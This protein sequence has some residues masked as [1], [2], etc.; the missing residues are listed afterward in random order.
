MSA[1]LAHQALRRKIE[2]HLRPGPSAPDLTAAAGRVFGRALRR[3]AGPFDGLGLLLGPVTVEA[4][5]PLEAAIAALP[6]QGLVA[7]LEDGGGQRGLMGLSP[8]LVDALV[9]VQTTGRVEAAELA[10][11][12]VTRIDEALARDF[13]DLALAGFA[14]EGQGI[15]GRDWPERMGYG[16][17]IR[18]RGQINLLL[19]EGGYMILGA[20]LGFEGV[21]RRA[22]LVLVLPQAASLSAA[23]GSARAKPADAAWLA[24]RARIMAEI[25]LPFEVVLLR[26]TR[27][28]AEVQKLAVGDLFPFSPADLQEVALEDGQGRAHLHGRLG[29]IGGRRALRLPGAVPVGMPAPPPQPGAAVALSPSPPASAPPPAPRIAAG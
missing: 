22:R 6:D 17:R 21:E 25:R 7:A 26:L 12:P 9:E 16:S 24:A 5:Q 2:A 14:Q 8:G 20:D 3:A 27:P 15:E 11:R 23:A 10:P 19:P 28:L 29:Q 4:A 13:L 1:P 18:D